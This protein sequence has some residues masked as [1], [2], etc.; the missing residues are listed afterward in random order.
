MIVRMKQVTILVGSRSLDSALQSLRRVGVVHVTPI[1]P[2]HSRNIDELTTRI[3]TLEKA[4]SLVA[5]YRPGLQQTPAADPVGEALR[6]LEI[7]D[8][9]KQ[10]DVLQQNLREELDEVA[11]WGEFDPAGVRELAASGIHISLYTATDKQLAALPSDRTVRI[12]ARVRGTVYLAL[13]SRDPNETL[14][15]TRV[16]LPRASAV[17][18]ARELDVARLETEQLSAQLRACAR[19]HDAFAAARSALIK[20]LEFE[21][22]RRGMR[23]DDGFAYLRG[24]CPVPALDTLRTAAEANRW[25]LIVEEPDDPS[26]VPTLL[27]TNRFTRMLQPLL[28]FFDLLPGYEEYDF[29]F[30]FLVFFSVFYAMLI[31]DAAYGLLFLAG[32]VVL[33]LR[34]P[35]A[36]R[37]LIALLY[38]LNVCTIIW[39]A[40]SG[41]WFGSRALAQWPPLR[42]LVVPTLDSFGPQSQA[43]VMWLSFIL[44]AVHLTLARLVAAVRT[45]PTIKCLGNLGWIPIV[46]GMYFLAEYFVLGQSLRPQT[47]WFISGGAIAVLS[48]IVLDRST[49]RETLMVLPITLPLDV[50]GSFSHVMSYVR[51]FAVGVASVSVA[52]AFNELALN[53]GFSSVWAGLIAAGVLTG[54]HILNIVL[55]VMAIIVHGVRLN[56]LEFSQHVGVEWKGFRYTPFKE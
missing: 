5:P 33:H 36:P 10:K 11:P 3:A 1:Q 55:G 40:M 22:V 27:R 30:F 45:L 35:K 7:A 44:G 26:A 47:V 21:R 39:G 52:Q 28:D 24:Y 15:F 53:L 4:V 2:P 14:P 19:H 50:I 12:I 20:D 48:A 16:P 54:G 29:S 23:E 32:T 9:I 17:T 43:F 13:A 38:V 46:W 49:S 51:L 34:T 56:L 37:Q 42:A 18:I 31:G 25:G 8:A 41:T 6:C